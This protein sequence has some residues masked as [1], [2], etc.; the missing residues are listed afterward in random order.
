MSCAY[1]ACDD[2]RALPRAD[3]AIDDDA[4][5]IW[6]DLVTGEGWTL[7]ADASDPFIDQAAERRRCSVTDYG[8]EYGGVEIS[9]TY[10]GY[11]TLEQAITEDLQ[12]GDVIELILWHSPLVSDTPA[13][14][15]IAIQLG[16][17]VLWSQPLTVPSEPKSW[18]D[19]VTIERPIGAGAMLYF[20]VHNHGSNAYTLLSVK[21][22]R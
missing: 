2:T 19:Y 9:T 21:R 10:C 14:G 5:L 15:L 6:V 1:I 13:Q 3:A 11:I 22:G 16:D 4:S 8:E 20:H 12:A 7:T 18:T 17:L